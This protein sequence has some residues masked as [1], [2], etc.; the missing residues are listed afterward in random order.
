MLSNFGFFMLRR[1]LLAVDDLE[2]FHRQY[3]EDPSENLLRNWYIQNPEA[4]EAVYLASSVLYERFLKWLA[5]EKLSENDKIQSTLYKYLVRMSTRSTPF[6]L[7]AVSSTGF[8]GTQTVLGVNRKELLYK[9]TKL[10]MEWLMAIKDWLIRQPG[11]HIHLKLFVNTSLY[12]IGDDYRYV[13]Q[14]TDQNQRSYFVSSILGNEYLESVFAVAQKGT[15]VNDLIALLVSLEIDP[16][17][18]LQF[19]EELIESKI[20]VF[21]IEPTVTGPGYFDLLINKISLIKNTYLAT[22]HLKSLREL[23]DQRE[24]RTEIYDKIQQKMEFLGIS[25]IKKD[26]VHVDTFSHS[27]ENRLS[28]KA[29]RILEQQVGQLR[30]LNRP[31]ANPDLETFK[32]RFTARYQDEEVALTSVLNHEM[33]IGYGTADSLGASHTPMIDALLFSGTKKT[34][35]VSQD[36]RWQNFVLDKYSQ[37]ITSNLKEIEVTQADL[38]DL[39]RTQVPAGKQTADETFPYAFYIFGNLLAENSKAVD[40]GTFLFNVTACGGPSAVN[41]LSRFHEADPVLH[42]QLAQCVRKEEAHNPKVIFAEI[43]HCPDSQGGNIMTRPTLH[44]Y[45][46][47]YLG[48]ASVDPSYQI[49]IQDLMVSVRSG[50][51]ILRSKKLNKRIIPRLSSAH[52]YTRGLPVYRFLCDLQSQDSGFN[53][54]WDWA[55]L[56]NQ[57]YLPRVRFKNLILSRASWRLKV[58]DFKDLS[59]EQTA[60]I[61]KQM[62]LPL[63]FVIASG[64]NELLIDTRVSLSL[65]ILLQQIN[66]DKEIRV[67]ETFAN[68]Q[69]CLSDD[70]GNHYANEMV[71]PLCNQNAVPLEGLSK[72]YTANPKRRFSVGSEWLYLKMY[73][74]E[75]SADTGILSHLY[76]VVE[77]LIGDQVISKFFFVR[78]QDPEPHIRLRFLVNGQGERYPEVLAAIQ[79]LTRQHQQ[80]GLIYKVQLDTYQRE[81]ERYGMEQIGLCESVFCLDSIQ[82]LKFLHQNSEVCDEDMRFSFAISQIDRLLSNADLSL[83]ERL[84]VAD[85][86][87]EDFFEEFGGDTK[88][89]KQ[90]S[91]QYRN[92]KPA[93]DFC[94]QEKQTYN[95]NPLKTCLSEIKENL[96][97][98]KQYFSILSSMIHMSVNRIFYSKQRAYELIIYHCLSKYYNTML[99]TQLREVN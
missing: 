49:P 10:D 32:E 63:Q 20:L 60:L 25:C 14:V 13:E 29:V 33:G 86:L 71:I 15:T 8:I 23:L 83:E 50:K 96:G 18:A 88:L 57:T 27:R 95:N 84:A 53:L 19:I 69:S 5:G 78:Y 74:E 7:F 4:Q 76:P 70:L 65:Q 31:K 28:E 22:G 97:D 68:G 39:S 41:M 82:V 34:G 11:I 64:D 16:D 38:N 40:D 2:V 9:H 58:Q 59:P 48:S 80:S 55:I 85:K 21:D 91:F 6:G 3:L 47:P 1:P 56:N 89:R 51:I 81:L 45:E 30:H 43:V 77:K 12:R 37:A 90:L 66:K 17:E 42:D 75:K 24:N 99:A 67:V 36:I 94:F 73:C 92:L 61:L 46:I 98:S 54:K 26:L 52:N 93:M 72:K 35:P 44:A 87:K 79:A 62:G